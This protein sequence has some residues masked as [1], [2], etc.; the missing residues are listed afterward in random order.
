[1]RKKISICLLLV[2]LLSL[3]LAAQAFADG[4]EAAQLGYVTDSTG[5]LSSGEKDELAQLAEKLSQEYRCGVY[6]V[7]LDDYREYARDI[8]TCAEELYRYFDLGWGEDRD[9]V[10]LI[11]SMQQREYD[12]AAYGDFGNY[13]FTDYG[14]D[15]LSDSFLDDFR[16]NEWYGG[17]QDYLYTAGDMLAKARSGEPVDVEPREPT[18]LGAGAKLLIAGAPACLAGFGVCS[19]AKSRMKSAVRRSTAEEY[20]VPGSASLY[21]R[22][23]RFLHRSRSVQIISENRGSSGGGGGTTVNAGG[24]SHHSGKF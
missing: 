14:K 15:V 4:E 10:L 6:I 13:A 8:E 20:V 16:H 7:V 1:M 19:A 23:D 12:I 24:F 18:R 5:S 3:T 11:M 21:I 9:G 17:F 22:Q 2:F